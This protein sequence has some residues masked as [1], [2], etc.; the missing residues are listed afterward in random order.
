MVSGLFLSRS[1]DALSYQVCVHI[2]LQ[3]WLHRTH[4]E[5]LFCII[6]T[7]HCRTMRHAGTKGE[8][9]YSFYS[10]STSAV[11]GVSSQRHIDVGLL[12]RNG[13]WT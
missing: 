8:R 7:K 4:F 2:L 12:G 5:I 6:I 11:D 13:V 10:F 1:G 3:D 9:S